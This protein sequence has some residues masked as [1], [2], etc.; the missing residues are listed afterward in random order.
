MDW[1]SGKSHQALANLGIGSWV[2][3]SALG[4]AKELVQGIV[5]SLSVVVGCM[6]ADV[7]SMADWIVN[8]TVGSWLLGS[9]VAIMGGVVAVTGG[10]AGVHLGTVMIIVASGGS[11]KVL[12]VSN[13]YFL[14]QMWVCWG[15][16]H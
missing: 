1:K 16:N 8:W 13:H 6:L 9:V 11:C 15:N 12:Q 4:V 14:R 2:D 7:T 3:L 10:R 5:I